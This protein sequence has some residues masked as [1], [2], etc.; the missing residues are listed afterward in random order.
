MSDSSASE[1]YTPRGRLHTPDD[2]NLSEFFTRDDGRPTIAR[3]ADL[4]AAVPNKEK[5]DLIEVD[6]YW[7]KEPYAFVTIFKSKDEKEYQYYV[8]EPTLTPEEKELVTFLKDK[9]RTSL[10]YEDVRTRATQEQR[11]ITLR[12]KAFELLRNY[13]LID[14]DHIVGNKDTI[15]EEETRTLPSIINK[16]IDIIYQRTA[17]D[18]NDMN[19]E[20]EKAVR[21]TLDRD[22]VEKLLYYVIRDFI[23]YE[24]IDPIKKDPN[25]ED[26]SVEGWEGTV[27]VLHSEYEQLITNV[28]F[29]REDLDE[30]VTTLAQKAN[31]GISKRQ[32]D[33]DATLEDG[34][35]A[36]LI[37]GDEITDKGSHFTIRDKNDIPFTPIDL[38][39]WGTY[40]LDQMVYLWL[41]VE[42]EK[43]AVI[44][45]GTTSGKTTTLNAISLFIPS[46]EKIVS[47]EDTRELQ[48]P[49]NNWIPLNTREAFNEDT[50]NEINETDLLWD[51]LRMSP[52]YVI[53]G[54]VRDPKAAR[55][56]FQNLNTGHTAFSTF[57]A[58]NAKEV[59]VRLTTDPI[60]IDETSFAGLNMIL[61]QARTDVDGSKVRRN[62]EIVEVQQYLPQANE[63]ETDT[64][65]TWNQSNDKMEG[66]L[67]LENI[68]SKSP[69][70]ETI[71][72][73]NG[74]SYDE[75]KDEINRRKVVLAY[76]LENDI[77]EYV[78]VASTLQGYMLSKRNVL[79]QIAEGSLSSNTDTFQ[80]MKNVDISVDTA[81]EEGIPRPPTSTK[82]RSKARDILQ[83]NE[84]LYTDISTTIDHQDSKGRIKEIEGKT[85]E[86]EE[87]DESALYPDSNDG[88]TD[89]TDE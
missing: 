36:L 44:A 81:L 83:T 7:V 35:R 51:S 52:E 87:A 14:Q 13:N 31:K 63:F 55:S 79:A 19:Y 82:M 6:R 86:K 50:A 74:W 30:F 60:N 77:K 10:N 22:Q 62:R 69:M 56:F 39:N 59:R 17:E 40:S 72:R 66:D 80:R 2:I 34:S 26:I 84:H 78:D 42:N 71:R 67:S 65:F 54:E 53:F 85:R 68:K 29:G 23:R 15:D 18:D 25:I 11:V 61:T 20:A 47:I 3:N 24:R 45:G 8:V 64:P 57:H 12:E 33:V 41:A 4:E 58:N 89:S 46:T 38:I 70:M 49:Q 48:V 43:S 32:P 9:I 27:S 21:H 16:T 37:L 73:E 75:L 76:M 1:N 28:K 5:G 88:S